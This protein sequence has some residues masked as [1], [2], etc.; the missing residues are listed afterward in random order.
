[1]LYGATRSRRTQ[2]FVES[3]ATRGFQQIIDPKLNA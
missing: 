2:L 3:R 1:M